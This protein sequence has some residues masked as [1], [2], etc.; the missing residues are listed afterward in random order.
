MS[1]CAMLDHQA[2]WIYTVATL[3]LLMR[4]IFGSCGTRRVLT[5][6]VRFLHRPLWDDV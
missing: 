5:G 1:I 6:G 4:R 2:R 3:G